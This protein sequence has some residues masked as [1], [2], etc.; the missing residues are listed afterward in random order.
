MV[1]AMCLDS[2]WQNIMALFPAMTHNTPL[3]AYMIFLIVHQL[4]AKAQGV[5][6]K[7]ALKMAEPLSTLVPERLE[8]SLAFPFPVDLGTREINPLGI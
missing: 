4:D 6:G 8:Q 5:I 3:P 2:L 7:P 1:V